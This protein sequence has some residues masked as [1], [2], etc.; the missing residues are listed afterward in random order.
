MAVVAVV[1][2]S[3]PE[4]AP[5]VRPAGSFPDAVIFIELIESCVGIGLQR[6]TEVSQMLLRMFALRSAE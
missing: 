5:H 1:Y 6:A 3:I 2:Q 4:L